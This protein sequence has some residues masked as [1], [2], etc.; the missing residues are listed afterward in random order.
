VE[1]DVTIRLHLAVALVAA[2]VSF[3][4]V[5]AQVGGTQR[6]SARRATELAKFDNPA[7]YQAPSGPGGTG[8]DAQYRSLIQTDS[9]ATSKG[10]PTHAVAIAQITADA[11]LN[12]NNLRQHKGWTLFIKSASQAYRPASA[13][14][15]LKA[16]YTSLVDLELGATPAPF[17]PA[18]PIAAGAP[19]R[20]FE[21]DA[22]L[23]IR[24]NVVYGTRDTAAQRMDAY[25]VKSA[26]PTPVL[27]EFHGGGWRRGARNEFT[28]YP[29]DLIGQA[30]AAGI[31][32]IS[33]DYRMTPAH[34]LQAI[35][36]DAL[37]AVQFVR[38]HAAEWNIDPRR[39]ITIGGSAGAHLAAWVALH[40]DVRKPG[41]S[42]PVERE[43][44]RVTAFV[45]LWGPM[46]LTRPDPVSMASLNL[47]GEDFA[48]A[49]TAACGCSAEQFVSDPAARARL[50]ALSP[51]FLVTKDDPPG[52]V[53]H[54]GPEIGG[55][56]RPIIAATI[57]DP[58]SWQQGQLLVNAMRDAGIPVVRYIAPSAGKDP[59]RDPAA[60][61]GFI[62]KQFGVSA[63]RQ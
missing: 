33:V 46:D 26:R 24:R 17:T 3:A 19:A 32:V 40:D 15:D 61:L 14:A 9:N 60:I 51:L 31:S 62:T 42:D 53:V 13:T 18:P 43:S 7:P 6:D 50:R 25:L 38:A 1:G 28:A 54:Q 48:A 27:V 2:V 52:I 12:A 37:R 47:R 20:P 35:T 30:I 58:H 55:D 22:R 36:D 41:S 59:E 39:I 4:P 21:G 8:W 63:P 29:S 10:L 45:D 34:T 49:F 44:S 23:T 16:L 11:A 57:N 56:T 5:S